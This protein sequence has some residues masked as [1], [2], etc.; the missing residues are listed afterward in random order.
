MAVSQ[1]TESNCH[2]DPATDNP[3]R[4][5]RRRGGRV[6]ALQSRVEGTGTVQSVWDSIR[7][8]GRGL[9]LKASYGMDA[10]EQRL[11][12]ILPETL[13]I[14]L[15]QTPAALSFTW[16][17]HSPDSSLIGQTL[18]LAQRKQEKK[19][20]L[21]APEQYRSTQQLLTQT[22]LVHSQ[23]HRHFG[24][25]LS[26]RKGKKTHTNFQWCWWSWQEHCQPSLV[27]VSDQKGNRHVATPQEEWAGIYKP[28]NEALG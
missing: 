21:I 22:D 25:F 19:D 20:P 9:H 14:E 10:K 6:S 4:C 18:M 2:A 5:G 12:L 8:S 16:Y 11:C 13:T 27:H 1:L 23:S 7:R 28:Y 15:F 26:H 3:R 17:R 24:M